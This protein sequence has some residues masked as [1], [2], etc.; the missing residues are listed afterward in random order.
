M[1]K[2][3]KKFEKNIEKIILK[4]IILK[5]TF[6]DTLRVIILKC[7]NNQTAIYS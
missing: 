7:N 3:K 6:S 2:L 4:N 5:I 1:K